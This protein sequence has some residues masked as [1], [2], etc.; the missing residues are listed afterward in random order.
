VP[1]VSILI[2][3]FNREAFLDD[4]IRS[5][6]SQVLTDLEVIIFDNASTD[7]SWEIANNFARSDSR[8]RIFR[9]D[10]NIGPVRN[11][12][13]CLDEANGEYVK[14][15]FSDD[16]ML[17]DFLSVTVPKL[18]NEHLAFVST[19]ALIGESIHES[20]VNYAEGERPEII[21]TEC[22]VSLLA[23]GDPRI[24]VSPGTA[25]FRTTDARQNLIWDIPT[26]TLH[27][28]GQNGAGP[29]LLLFA[30][31]AKNYRFAAFIDQ[32]LVFFRAHAG[33]LTISDND[34]ILVEGYR[35]A[36]AWFLRNHSSRKNWGRLVARIWLSQYRST[37]HL[38]D[39]FKLT[40]RYSGTGRLSDVGRILSGAIKLIFSRFMTSKVFRSEL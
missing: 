14:F 13:R 26:A 16:L 18:D 22:Y 6:L 5:A 9:N 39:P 28:F 27:D 23:D 11:W 4:C 1:K 12:R 21:S 17:P 19:A 29:D 20:L 25:I 37:R 7:R 35:L 36:L 38:E 15:L 10:V 40:K 32:P 30:L 8:V 24:P 34:S 33:S 2:P 3:V 31:T